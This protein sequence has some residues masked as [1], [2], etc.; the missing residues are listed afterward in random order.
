MQRFERDAEHAHEVEAFRFLKNGVLLV[1]NDEDV[2]AFRGRER[3][4][5][6]RG[7]VIVK[8]YKLQ[9][10]FLCFRRV[11]VGVNV[12]D[13]IGNGGD[14]N[15]RLLRYIPNGHFFH[16]YSISQIYAGK[17]SKKRYVK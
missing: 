3:A 8:V 4:R 5:K 17:Q 13:D 10:L 6:A 7:P 2:P 1:G 11:F 9:H 16:V 12:V 15:A 14:G